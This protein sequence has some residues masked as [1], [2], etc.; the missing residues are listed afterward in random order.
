M[1]KINKKMNKTLIIV[2]VQNDFCPGGSLAVEKGAEIIPVINTLSESG[3]FKKIITTQDWHPK[4]HI[5]F[6]D[7]C[8]TDPFQFNEEAGQV[9]WPVHCVQGTKGAELHPNLNTKPIQY[10][11]RK[12][13]NPEID[14]YSGFL[15]NDKKTETGLFNLIDEKDL[16]Y[17]CGIATDVC[18]FNTAMDAVKGKFKQVF[19]VEDAC[20]GVTEEG[21][22]KALK[23][24]QV[25]GVKIIQSSSLI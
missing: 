16:L 19:I 12:G 13:M 3:L 23:E 25:A 22:L 24:L 15:E 5:S 7:N 8:G 17:I 10:I 18:V 9:V 6:S 14:S 11:L 2:D 21:S 4:Q 20:A 1:N